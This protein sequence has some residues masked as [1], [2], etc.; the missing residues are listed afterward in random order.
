MDLYGISGSENRNERRVENAISGTESVG[1]GAGL[2]L[3]SSEIVEKGEGSTL[4]S[5]GN[6]RGKK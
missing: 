4:G 2:G 6:E 5:G 1:C 3:G